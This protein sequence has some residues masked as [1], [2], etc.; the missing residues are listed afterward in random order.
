MHECVFEKERPR[1]DSKYSKC[2]ANIHISRPFYPEAVSGILSSEAKVGEAQHR[3]DRQTSRQAILS[4]RILDI[5]SICMASFQPLQ[6]RWRQIQESKAALHSPE[7]CDAPLVLQDFEWMQ[8]HKG[9]AVLDASKVHKDLAISACSKLKNLWSFFNSLLDKYNFT[10][11]A[12]QEQYPL[13]WVT[14]ACFMIN[15]FYVLYIIKLIFTW[16]CSLF[17]WMDT[18]GLYN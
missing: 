8:R 13:A 2:T 18:L 9:S 4:K 15:I 16:L 6:F 5:Y 1:P 14:W 3:P 12:V 17:T 11:G 7:M 10:T